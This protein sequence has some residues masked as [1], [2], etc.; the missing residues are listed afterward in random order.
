M[1]ILKQNKKV[2]ESNNKI[3]SFVKTN[4]DLLYSGF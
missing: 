4:R 3:Y 2:F 1:K